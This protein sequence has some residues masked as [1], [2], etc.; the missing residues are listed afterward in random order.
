M[1]GME[2]PERPR[3]GVLV[4]TVWPDEDPELRLRA[5]FVMTAGAGGPPERSAAAGTAQRVL[6]FLA[7]S[8]RALH[9][10]FVA[11]AIAVETEH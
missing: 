11:G 5:R 8:D 9:R 6:A 2:Q 4:V 7:L 10:P 3:F 1:D